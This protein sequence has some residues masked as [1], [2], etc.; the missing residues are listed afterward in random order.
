MILICARKTVF[1][2]VLQPSANQEIVDWFRL[3]IDVGCT[4]A[5]EETHKLL[6]RLQEEWDR[7]IA[8]RK[9]YSEEDMKE[10][11]DAIHRLEQSNDELI[12]TLSM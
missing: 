3:P 9:V 4:K 7:Q 2:F 1:L 6:A 12:E 8:K 10:K 5:I 11:E